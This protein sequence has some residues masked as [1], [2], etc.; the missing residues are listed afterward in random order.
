MLLP[1]LPDIYINSNRLS[2]VVEFVYSLIS[3]HRESG[4]GDIVHS[5]AM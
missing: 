4:E 2:I 1:T 5:N 3:F